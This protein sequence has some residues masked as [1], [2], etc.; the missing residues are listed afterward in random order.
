MEK[1]NLF[2]D[3]ERYTDLAMDLNVEACQVIKPLF[4]KYISLG[5]KIREISFILHQSVTDIELDNIL[6]LSIA[7]QNAQERT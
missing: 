3:H 6:D 2:N 7:P 1:I 4:D 5:C